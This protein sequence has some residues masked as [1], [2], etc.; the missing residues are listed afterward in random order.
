MQWCPQGQDMPA[1][2]CRSSWGCQSPRPAQRHGRLNMPLKLS[3]PNG[4]PTALGKTRS[5]SC[6][7]APAVTRST[8]WRARWC[9][10][11]AISESVSDKILRD[12]GVFNSVN[13]SCHFRPSGNAPSGPA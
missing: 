2:E 8:A 11:A 12:R 3:G 13:I 10:S 5:C 1:R 7:S 9:W 6:Q 4:V